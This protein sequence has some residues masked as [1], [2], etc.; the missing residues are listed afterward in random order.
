M[1]GPSTR[2]LDERKDVETLNPSLQGV[3]QRKGLT[4]NKADPASFAAQ[5]KK[6]GF[7]TEW[8][9]KYGDGAW[10]L[11]EQATGKLT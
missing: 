3:L 10:S 8:K 4:F 2:A 5:L 9:G 11:L 6:A 1:P 7:Y